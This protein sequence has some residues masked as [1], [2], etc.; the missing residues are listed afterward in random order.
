MV[1]RVDVG[2]DYV[3]CDTNPVYFEVAD[4]KELDSHEF[5]TTI[6]NALSNGEFAHM[7]LDITPVEPDD[8]DED[9]IEEITDCLGYNPFE[10]ED[11]E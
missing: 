11:E 4:E 9:E 1:V 5:S 6:L 8:V 10:E 7:F 2:T 3:A